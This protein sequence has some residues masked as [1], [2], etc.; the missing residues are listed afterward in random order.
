MY[1]FICISVSCT[2]TTHKEDHTFLYGQLDMDH[3]SL[4]SY[5]ALLTRSVLGIR[6]T[7]C[8]FVYFHVDLNWLLLRGRYVQASLVLLPLCASLVLLPL[9][10][11]LVLLPLCASLVL[12]PLCA[13]PFSSDHSVVAE[14]TSSSEA[15]SWREMPLNL[16]D[17]V[18]LS[19]YVSFF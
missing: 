3:I 19:Y 7:A 8:N 18:S 13:S 1:M 9:C 2:W 6:S 11:S 12:L 14:E 5:L 17:I 10:A 15:R 4:K 16:S